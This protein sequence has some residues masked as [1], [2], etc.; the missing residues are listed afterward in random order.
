[1]KSDLEKMDLVGRYLAGEASASEAS[2]LEQ[3]MLADEQLRQDFLAYARVDAALPGMISR[4]GSLLDFA[5]APAQTGRSW[6]GWI[7]AAVAVCAVFAWLAYRPFFRRKLP[8]LPTSQ[9]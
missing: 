4:T 1:M 7:P 5:E 8:K 6:K 3:L 9:N 2:R